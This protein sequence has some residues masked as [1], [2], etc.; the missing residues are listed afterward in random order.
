MRKEKIPRAEISESTVLIYLSS[1]FRDP[2]KRGKGKVVPLTL[3]TELYGLRNPLW[4]KYGLKLDT[5]SIYSV[6]RMYISALVSC[7]SPKVDLFPKWKL[8]DLI[9]YLESRVLNL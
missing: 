6:P 8:K 5:T 3:R 4:A 2:A 1:R 9:D 7:P